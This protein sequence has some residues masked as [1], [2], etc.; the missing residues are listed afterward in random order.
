MEIDSELWDKQKTDV[1]N[2][3]KMGG[4]AILED[5]SYETSAMKPLLY[6]A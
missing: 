2:Q 4:D 5:D 1:S 6:D 3:I